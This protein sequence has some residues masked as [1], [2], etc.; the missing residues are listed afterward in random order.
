MMREEATGRRPFLWWSGVVMA[1][2]PELDRDAIQ[3]RGDFSAEL[4]Q[5]TTRLRAD[6]ETLGRFTKERKAAGAVPGGDVIRARVGVTEARLHLVSADYLARVAA[7][8]LATAVGLPPETTLNVAPEAAA[9]APPLAVG[10]EESMVRALE[11]RP[12]LAAG[13]SH[14]DA[15][16]GSVDAVPSQFGPMLS[17][18]WR[19]GWR[20]SAWLPE[21][22]DWSVGVA[23]QWTLF[24]RREAPAFPGAGAG[25]TVPGRSGVVRPSAGGAAGSLGLPLPTERELRGCAGRGK[26][27]DRRRGKPQGGARAIPDWRGYPSGPVGRGCVAGAGGRGTRGIAPRSQHRA[28]HLR[29][30]HRNA[31]RPVNRAG[32]RHA[33]QERPEGRRRS[34]GITT[35]V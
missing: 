23:L 32:G 9:L 16:R 29:M 7:G 2:R 11:A 31:R 28:R 22:R 27:G 34:V 8:R 4:L 14:V 10:L 26:P 5:L 20:D 6:S 13:Q 35:H 25:R 19:L 12:A 15:A 18:D 24:G 3:R 1:T 21:D 33:E 17:T 30:G